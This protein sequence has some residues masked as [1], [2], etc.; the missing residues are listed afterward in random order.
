MMRRSRGYVPQSALL[1]LEAPAALGCGAELKSTFCVAKGARAWPSH[2][3]GDLK[4]W[5]TLE[6]FREGV[7][8]FQRLFAV[9]PQVIAHDLHPDYLSSRYAQQRVDADPGLRL[10]GVQHHHAHLAACL[11]E[12]GETG[13]ALGIIFDGTGYG[14]DA[15]VW[16]GELLDGDLAGFERVG[17]LM[18]VR[19][20]GGDRAV[21]EP[22]RMAASWL[23]HALDDELPGI[24]RTLG[25]TVEATDWQAVCGIVQ[26]GVRSPVT[27]SAGRLFDAVSALCGVRARVSYEGQAAAELEGAADPSVRDRYEITVTG[28]E[29]AGPLVI[30]PRPAIRGVVRDIGG[31]E[32]VAAISARFHNG[33]ADAVAR[34]AEHACRERGLDKVVLS[35]GVFQNRLLLER[36]RDGLDKTGLQT[37]VPVALPP[38]DGGISFGQVA[39]AAARAAQ[40]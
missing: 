35:G 11:A 28:G 36:A 34:A 24:P 6:S 13:R 39:V 19:L 38:N 32:P 31:G 5:E 15:S 2:H 1:P 14:E 23:S 21:Q 33:I 30:D 9:E 27:T 18:P 7:E 16:G 29:E 8:H 12:H 20:P 25:E 4:N 26:T 37:L 22:W 17:M 40:S 3:V 10:V